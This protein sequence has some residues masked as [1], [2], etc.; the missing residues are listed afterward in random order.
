MK[1]AT[2]S[3]TI[4]LHWSVITVITVLIYHNVFSHEFQLQWDDQWQVINSMTNDEISLKNLQTILA[5]INNSQYSPINHQFY[6]V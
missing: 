1:T 6:T 2:T 5:S 3:Q 4:A